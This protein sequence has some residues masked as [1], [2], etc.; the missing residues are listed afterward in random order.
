MYNAV[1]SEAPADEFVK[2]ASE[3]ELENEI[4]KARAVAKAQIDLGFNTLKMMRLRRLPTEAITYKTLI[5][6]CGRCGIAHRAQTMMEMMTQDGMALDSEVVFAFIKAFSNAEGG[7]TIPTS[8]TSAT[9]TASEF[10]AS[11][12]ALSV[13]SSSASFLNSSQGEIDQPKKAAKKSGNKF[14]DGLQNAVSST[15]ESNRRAFK[16]AKTRRMKRLAKQRLTKRENLRVTRS[17]QTQLEL[18]QCLLENLYPGLQIDAANA[19]CP[20]CSRVLSHDE[21]IMGWKPCQVED[22]STA[23]PSCKHRFVPKFT[24]S[25]NSESFEGSQGVNTTLFCFFLSP[26]VLLQEIRSLIT[27]SVGGKAAEL[28]GVESNEADLVGIEGIIDPKF[29]EGTGINATLWWNLIVTFTRFKIPF[30][31][32]LQGSYPDQQLI[33]PTLEDNIIDDE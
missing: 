12:S 26:W 10:S 28:L 9:D 3:E 27:P 33:M 29:R 32:L 16:N 20:K 30:T 21:V 1:E 22:S 24:V 18:S 11:K 23:C 4:A 31:F 15:I 14:M 8:L 6:A 25:C 17:I 19:T 13:T 2:S 7:H 5:E